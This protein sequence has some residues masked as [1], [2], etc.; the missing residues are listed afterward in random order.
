M[1]VCISHFNKYA[2]THTL[3]VSDGADAGIV[4]LILSPS[5]TKRMWLL[6]HR[7]LNNTVFEYGWDE[8]NCLTYL[9]LH[10]RIYFNCKKI[11]NLDYTVLTL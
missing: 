1:K 9:G 11:K 7:Y 5:K 8:V 4:L 10:V 3:L 6:Y 2:H